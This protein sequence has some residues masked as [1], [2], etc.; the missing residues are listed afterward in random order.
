MNHRRGEYNSGSLRFTKSHITQ[1]KRPEKTPMTKDA[2]APLACQSH[3]P[4]QVLMTG[5]KTAAGMVGTTDDVAHG[6]EETEIAERVVV[7]TAKVETVTTTPL[8]AVDATGDMVD[9]C[10]VTTAVGVSG[11]YG[12]SGVILCADPSAV[13]PW[14][15]P[16]I[17]AG[18]CTEPSLAALSKDARCDRKGSV[19]HD[20]AQ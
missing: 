4:A 2:T 19:Y 8:G 20:S 18:G 9:S 14:M 11:V 16:I 5:L 15:V 1:T 13:H 10:G 6:L 7:M 3:C 17:E 12:R